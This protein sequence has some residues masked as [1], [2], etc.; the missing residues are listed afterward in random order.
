MPH[1]SSS[2]D[3]IFRIREEVWTCTFLNNFYRV[4][5]DEGGTTIRN[6]HSA[7]DA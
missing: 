6:F 1:P 5:D 7:T 2:S 4:A 3:L